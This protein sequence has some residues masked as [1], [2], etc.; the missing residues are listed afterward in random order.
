MEKVGRPKEI[1]EIDE[2]AIV[3][4]S[5]FGVYLWQLIAWNQIGSSYYQ[6]AVVRGC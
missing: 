2:I 3:G 4:V 1:D 5:Q 6:V